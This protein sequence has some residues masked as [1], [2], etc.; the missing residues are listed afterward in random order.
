MLALLRSN[1][2][3]QN[4]GRECCVSKRQKTTTHAIANTE[5]SNVL[6]VLKSSGDCL[7]VMNYAEKLVSPHNPNRNSERRSLQLK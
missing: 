1:I 6:L 2:T 5:A 4:C 3:P 7:I